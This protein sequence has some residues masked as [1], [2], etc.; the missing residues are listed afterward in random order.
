LYSRSPLSFRVLF[1]EGAMSHGDDSLRGRPSGPIL[2][3]SFP[4]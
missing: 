3:A 1:C 2:H 4:G